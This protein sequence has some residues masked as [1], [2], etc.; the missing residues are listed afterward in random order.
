MKNVRWGERKSAIEDMVLMESMWSRCKARVQ[1]FLK[2]HQVFFFS[3]SFDE[4]VLSLVIISSCHFEGTSAYPQASPIQGG[5]WIRLGETFPFISLAV[6]WLVQTPGGI[7][8]GG[9]CSIGTGKHAFWA[10]REA[11]ALTGIPGLCLH[12]GTCQNLEM[13]AFGGCFYP[14]QLPLYWRYTVYQFMHSLGF[15]QSF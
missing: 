4:D 14:K 13:C 1:F 5:L 10:S 9:L 7:W 6:S 8:P 2:F 12:T 11:T 3:C 15:D